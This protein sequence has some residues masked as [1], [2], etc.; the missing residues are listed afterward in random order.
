MEQFQDSKVYLLREDSL[1]KR[2]QIDENDLHISGGKYKGGDHEVIRKLRL[3]QVNAA[4][5]KLSET[6]NRQKHQSV[7]RE[8][9]NQ[10]E[11]IQ[12]QQLKKLSS[13]IKFDKNSDS[14]LS[15]E[16]QKLSPYPINRRKSSLIISKLKS[17]H[18][19]LIRESKISVNNS[20]LNDVLPAL[21]NKKDFNKLHIDIVQKVI[22][23]GY[24]Y[25][26]TQNQTRFSKEF[27]K[28][29]LNNQKSQ[30]QSDINQIFNTRQQTSKNSKQNR[31]VSK[32]DIEIS[33][34]GLNID[35]MLEKQLFDNESQQLIKSDLSQMPQSLLKTQNK[36]KQQRKLQ[37]ISKD[38]NSLLLS[39][40]GRSDLTTFCEG[41]E[42]SKPITLER[43]GSI[44]E[45]DHN[46]NL[47]QSPQ[48]FDE[49]L[50]ESNK[51]S[52]RINGQT[53]NLES[54]IK[55]LSSPN[56]DQENQFFSFNKKNQNMQIQDINIAQNQ[57]KR[58]QNYND[59]QIA[60]QAL[61]NFEILRNGFGNSTQT[62]HNNQ[63]LRKFLNKLSQLENK[64]LNC[65]KTKLDKGGYH[66]RLASDQSTKYQNAINS[67][68]LLQNLIPEKPH[69]YEV[70]LD[71]FR[72]KQEKIRKIID[73]QINKEK[74]L[75]Q[76]KY[77]I[78][79]PAKQMLD[80]SLMRKDVS[81]LLV[82]M[83]KV[84]LF[85][86][87]AVNNENE[88]LSIIDQS[89]KIQ[90]EYRASHDEM[91]FN[92]ISYGNN[93]QR[94]RI[95][96]YHSNQIDHQKELNQ[97]QI[98]Y[99]INRKRQNRRRHFSVNQHNMLLQPLHSQQLNELLI[100][101]QQIA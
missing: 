33:A 86:N 7:L 82:N 100:K 34:N 61:D 27:Q 92:N 40:L 30:S 4:I 47:F 35:Q 64:S 88:N 80:Q 65:S 6:V 50:T 28:P 73:H 54:Q 63:K 51:K 45:T 93:L 101:Q 31:K 15:P 75:L 10:L 76:F 39:Q 94:S 96:S 53:R 95:S 67:Y 12:T 38:Q 79:N 89:M 44:I 72:L 46:M 49:F 18:K 32:K 22:N 8:R 70:I 13:Q 36:Q 41:F 91:T 19:K 57:T 85:R 48:T 9:P 17:I 16:R 14:V 43:E 60:S 29:Q 87:L 98:L 66:R 26:Q 68:E 52:A 84:K 5:S 3:P 99:N 25:N 42:T 55:F 78:S 24:N 71:E 11:V 20:I 74:D 1:I 81:I 58:Y 2:K 21:E 90:Q 83:D 37:Y 56:E 69:D 59:H 23:P 77:D 62:L 97:S